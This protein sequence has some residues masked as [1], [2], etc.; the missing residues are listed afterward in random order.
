[1]KKQI[2][3]AVK[4]LLILT[5]VTGVIYPLIITGIA[6]VAFPSKANGSL[7]ASNGK[8]VGSELIGQ[9]TDSVIYFHG[10]PSSVGYNPMPSGGSNWGP[11]ADTLRKIMDGNRNDF[12]KANGLDSNATVP[13]EMITASASGLDPDISPEAARL[14]I[15]RVASARHFSAEQTEKLRQLVE[16][17][18]TPPQ[19][20]IL[21]EPRVNVLALNIALDSLK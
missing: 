16:S 9:G 8:I 6:E 1:M 11:I 15:G 13:V 19:F 4:M 10:R 20:G 12:I 3:A 21:G 17:M 2:V 5:V 7:I 14:Q 18:V